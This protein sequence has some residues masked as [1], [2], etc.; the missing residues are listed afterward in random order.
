MKYIN[1]DTYRDQTK[2][3]ALTNS[4]DIIVQIYTVTLDQTQTSDKAKCD[5]KKHKTSEWNDEKRHVA[6][7]RAAALN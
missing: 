4:E 3:Y 1:C 5:G 7:S 6:Y 2:P